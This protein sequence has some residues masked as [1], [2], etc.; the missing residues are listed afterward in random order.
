MTTGDP[1]AVLMAWVDRGG[2]WP[3]DR[4]W[5]DGQSSFGAAWSACEDG[6]WLEWAAKRFGFWDEVKAPRAAFDAAQRESVR[7]Y[8]IEQPKLGQAAAMDAYSTRARASRVAFADA[9]RAAVSGVAAEAA[10]AK[11]WANERAV[12]AKIRDRRESNDGVY[13]G[14]DD[15]SELP[16]RPP[17]MTESEGSGER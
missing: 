8:Y 14:A 2:P 17:A 10:L 13:R 12:E 6:R 9:V 4:A 15:W 1:K 11:W 3:H 7:A 16:K 5:A